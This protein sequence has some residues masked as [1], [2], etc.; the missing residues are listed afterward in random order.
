[1]KGEQLAAK[2]GKYEMQFTEE[3][4]EVTYLDH[5]KLL[6]VDHPADTEIFPN[7]LFKFPPFPDAHIHTV[8][9]ALAP[10]SALGS[11]GEDWRR[12]LSRIDDDYAMPMVLQPAQFAGLAQPWFLELAFDKAA[13]AKA[14]KMRLLMTGWFFW[15]DASANMASA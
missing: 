6:V 9:G 12:A 14:K 15:S 5:A 7:E 8:K 3:L 11:D 10:A 13:V 1:V 2:D 4:R